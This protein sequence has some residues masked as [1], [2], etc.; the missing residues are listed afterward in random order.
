M[1]EICYSEPCNSDCPNAPVGRKIGVCKACGYT[2]LNNDE[3]T[4]VKINGIYNKYHYDCFTCLSAS[5]FVSDFAL[6]AE[7]ITT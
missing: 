4:A 1:F 3:V 2:L 7:I 5:D 6:S